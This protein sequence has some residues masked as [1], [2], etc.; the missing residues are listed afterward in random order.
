[1]VSRGIIAVNWKEGGLDQNP[2]L[3]VRLFLGQPRKHF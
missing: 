2:E 3:Q 1:M